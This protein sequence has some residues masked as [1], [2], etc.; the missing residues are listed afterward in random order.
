M[1]A[2]STARITDLGFA[3]TERARFN[4][5]H[6][7]HLRPFSPRLQNSSGATSMPLTRQVG[8]PFPLTLTATR[9][10]QS[11]HRT[12]GATSAAGKFSISNFTVKYLLVLSMWSRNACLSMYSAILHRPQCFLRLLAGE[13]Y[14]LAYIEN[15]LQ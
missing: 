2:T 3:S 8:I 10:L 13:E 9:C 12:T 14:G 11:L 6:R 7:C 4:F 15:I 5:S 1:T